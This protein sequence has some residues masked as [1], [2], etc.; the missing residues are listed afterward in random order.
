MDSKDLADQLALVPA[1]AISE[2]AEQLRDLMRTLHRISDSLL[3]APTVEATSEEVPAPTLPAVPI[4]EPASTSGLRR[5]YAQRPP[6]PTGDTS[7]EEEEGAVGGVLYATDDQESVAV[8]APSTPDATSPYSSLAN[9]AS[10]PQG[11]GFRRE[12]QP[13]ELRW[14]ALERTLRT[15]REATIAARKAEAEAFRE[16]D[17][18]HASSRWAKEFS[19]PWAKD[20]AKR[21]EESEAEQAARQG[22]RERRAALVAAEEARREIEAA[23]EEVRQAQRRL[24]EAQA[25]ARRAEERA[26]I[27]PA[28]PPCPA[29]ATRPRVPAPPVRPALRAP[30]PRQPAPAGAAPE[31]RRCYYCGEPGVKIHWKCPNF[32][33]HNTRDPW[34]KRR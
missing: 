23:Q 34:F 11:P 28:R 1:D 5:T 4:V 15:A 2:A 27:A 32:L 25:R 16:W 10:P 13:L 8:S 26:I 19:A 9:L 30:Q 29:P 17:A 3:A 14:D 7:E 31:G 22:V 12:Q 20:V 6:T 24:E 18:F 33:N 21:R